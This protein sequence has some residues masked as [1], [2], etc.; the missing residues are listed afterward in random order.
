MN[1]GQD[2]QMQMIG[3]NGGNQ[4]RQYAGQNAGNLN[5][6]NEVQNVGN[7]VAQKPR[8]Q[9]VGNQN[10]LIGVQRNGNLVAARAEGNAAGQNANQ[11]RCY[12]YRGFGHYARN[13]TARPRRKDAA[14]LQTQLLIA[15]KKEAGIQLQAKEYDLMAAAADLDEIEE[16]NANCILMANLQQASSSG[17]Q[18]DS[19]PVYD[20]DGSAEVHE[21]KNCYNN[22]IFNM[23]TQEEQYTELLEPIPESQQVPQNDINVI[24]ENLAI[25]VEK[26]NSVNR[27][28]KETNA[29]LTTELARQYAGQN[30]GNPAGYNDVIGNQIGNGNLVATRAEGN[31]AG[32]N[33]NQIRCYNCRGVGHYARNCTVRPRRR[34]AAYLQTQLLIAQKEEVG[35]QLQAEKYDLMAAAADLDEIKEV[36]GNCIL[37][38]NLQQSSTSGTQTDSAPVYDTDRSAEVHENYDDNEIFNMFTQEEQYTE[39]LE[40]IYESHQV[41]HNDNDVISEDT[42]MEQGGETVEQHLENFEETRALYESLYQNLAIKVEKVNSVNRRLKETNADMTTELARYKNQ[43]S[44]ETAQEIWLR[45]QQMMKGADIGIQEK[46]AKLFN[47]WEMFTSNE[48]ESI[49]YYYHRFLKLMNDLKRNKHF[50]EKIASNL[51]FLNNL[52]PE[53]SRHVTIVHQTKDLH[54][55]DYTQLYDFLKYNQ[56]EVDE[57]KAE[58][59]AKTQDPLTLMMVGGNGG[60]QFR[61]YAGHN[62]G[63][64][65]GY[66]DVTGNQVNQNAVQNLKVQNI[67]NQNGL[68]GVQGNVNQNQIGSGNLVAARAEENAAGQNGNQIRCYNCKGKEE[69]GIQLQAEE[70]DLMATA[71]D[72]D[73]IEEVNANCILMANLQQA[74]TSG[75]YSTVSPPCST[76]V[77]LEITSLSFCGYSDLFM[78]RRFGLFQAYDRKSKA[79]HQFHLE[80]YENGQFCD[81]DL[82]V[83]FRRNACFVRNLEGVDLLKGDRSTN[84]YTINLHEMASASPICLMARA[85]STKSWLWHQR[86]SHLNFDTIDDLARNDLVAEAARTMLIFSR[87]PLFLWAE[88]IATACFTQNRSIIHR[89]FNKTPYE[90]INGRKPDISF[91]Y[92]FGA[93]CYPK[94]DREDTGKLGA[95]G[96]IGFFI[97]Y[98]ADFCAYRVFNRRTKKIMETMNVSF[99]ELSAMAF[100]QRSSKPRLQSMTS[101]Q[102]SSGLDLTYAPST[103][104]KQQPS[105]GEPSR[106]V[107]TRNQLRSD[108]DMSMYALTFKMLNVWVLVPAPYNISPLTLKWLFKNKHDEE[109]TVIQNNSRLVVRGY[110]QEEGIDFEES[111]ASVA[112]IGAIGILLAYVAH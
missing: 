9:N 35:I 102:I 95:K 77:S 83:T 62:T 51:K 19:A 78:V 3:G 36:N 55:A 61:Q 29:D 11:I 2:R 88:A 80:V 66:N 58:R 106:P 30:A 79:S 5:G 43:E 59:L 90:L 32:Q 12:N 15:Q 17:T 98:S 64:P 56:K 16:V 13:C 63:N 96:D 109:Q 110:R 14:Y 111:F 23:F 46:K 104:T 20:S 67:G 74:S 76:P 73:E 41:R 94:N 99:D 8:V 37:M 7:Q 75:C 92:V 25:E 105:E 60:N 70:Y 28:L 21:Y 33:G 44:C 72:L 40:P 112:R 103:I 54:T 10:G 100:E 87:A 31:A 52:Q 24:S 85:S 108:G 97:G 6:Y 49:K 65:V 22:E 84:L 93:L 57:L 69:A 42:S 107:L 34:D 38:A 48:G 26:V 89:R 45:V 50:P 39:L 82:E 101:G 71:A 81:S 1:M 47:E 86:L 4:F 27:K 68:I 91:L 18:T 53:W